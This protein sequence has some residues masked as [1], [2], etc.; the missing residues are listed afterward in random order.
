MSKKRDKEYGPKPQDVPL[1]REYLPQSPAK[2]R[3]GYCKKGK[4]E[5]VFELIDVNA[6]KLL[7]HPQGLHG[8]AYL[9][10]FWRWKTYRCSACGK[11]RLIDEQEM[12]DEPVLM[13]KEQV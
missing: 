5:H 3:S 1:K 13:E 8:P 6:W 2:L 4:G 12:L 9:T 11:K 10:G 7:S